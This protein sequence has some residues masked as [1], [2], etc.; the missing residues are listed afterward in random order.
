MQSLPDNPRDFIYRR[1][2]DQAVKSSS[3]FSKLESLVKKYGVMSYLA[4]RESGGL[5]VAL[6][7]HGSEAKVSYY[8]YL[9]SSL[10]K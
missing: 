10:K 1:Y 3:D 8:G 2:L 7:A 4:C 6:S 5:G 9:Y